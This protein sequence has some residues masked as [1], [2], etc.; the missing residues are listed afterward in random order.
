MAAFEDVGSDM[1][2]CAIVEGKNFLL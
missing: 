1:A 2:A